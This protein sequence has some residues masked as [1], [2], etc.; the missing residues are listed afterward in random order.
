M[1]ETISE[2]HQA[3]NEEMTTDYANNVMFEPS[4]WD[5][6]LIFGE[7]SQRTGSVDWHTSITLPWAQVKLMIYY[8]QANVA[9]YEINEGKIRVPNPALPPEWPVITP[10][11]AENPKALET[12]ET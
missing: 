4:I 10:E 3:K 8:L 5:L 6:K 1:G 7:F 12:S 9:A 2:T 11:Q